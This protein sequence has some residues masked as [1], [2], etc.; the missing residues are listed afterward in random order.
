MHTAY[1]HIAKMIAMHIES[2]TNL[3]GAIKGGGAKNKYLVQ[4]IQENTSMHCIPS[5]E[6]IDF[7]ESLSWPMLDYCAY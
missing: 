7:K 6:I 4:L 2:W 5:D 3:Q 1:I